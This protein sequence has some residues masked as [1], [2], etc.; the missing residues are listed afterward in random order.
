[1]KFGGTAMEIIRPRSARTGKPRAAIIFDGDDT[2]WVTEWLYDQAG[3]ELRLIV[4]STG[5][6][7]EAWEAEFRSRDLANVK[8]FG[9]NSGRFATSAVTAYSIL[10]ERSGIP[11]DS[12]IVSRLARAAGTVFQRAAPTVA[13]A[14]T[15]LGALHEDYQL[16]LL[17]KGDPAVQR[18]RLADS[19]LLKF[20][21]GVVI[22]PEKSEQTFRDVCAEFDV[23]V[24]R[25]WAVG[26]SLPSD[27]VPAVAAGLQGVWVDA[28]SWEYEKRG[29]HELPRGAVALD[30]LSQLPNLIARALDSVRHYDPRRRGPE[31]PGGHDGVAA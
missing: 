16:I 7:G 26:N 18:K 25:S 15:T 1:M 14:R 28:H 29:G 27:I 20:F 22:V 3:Q 23:D 21:D 13:G 12:H 17:T 24:T 19:G 5:L 4:E 11:V 9:F 30:R 2:L 8:Q 31:Q 10:C 6:D